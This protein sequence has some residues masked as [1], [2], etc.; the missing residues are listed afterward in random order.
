[1]DE[2][3]TLDSL[4]AGHSDIGVRA[5]TTAYTE[6]ARFLLNARDVDGHRIPRSLAVYHCIDVATGVKRLVQQ[7]E[8]DGTIADLGVIELDFSAFPTTAGVE[9]ATLLAEAQADG[10]ES[11]AEWT[12]WRAS[13]RKARAGG[14]G[15]G[16]GAVPEAVPEAGAECETKRGP[17]RPKGSAKKTTADPG[18]ELAEVAG[19]LTLGDA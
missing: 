3:A 11:V 4:T 18:E 2:T 1:M 12:A 16:A 13:Q 9:D 6:T 19:A 14:A 5:I 7:R 17:G 10:F 15:G 8:A